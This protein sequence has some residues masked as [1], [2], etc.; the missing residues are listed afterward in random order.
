MPVSAP[1]TALQNLDPG[2]VAGQGG[3]RV[4]QPCGLL[5]AG[6]VRLDGQPR[7]ACLA[8]EPEHGADLR[9]Q[10]ARWCD[11]HVG[12]LAPAQ[13]SRLRPVDGIPF[14]GREPG[15]RGGH[16]ALLI[17]MRRY[18]YRSSPPAVMTVGFAGV[19]MAIRATSAPTAVSPS[20]R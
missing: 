6:Q 15:R 13:H 19:V 5:I 9:D 11:S 7:R 3:D 8:G 2:P 17:G 18:R 14:A 20:A 16:P 1:G 4:A 12:E 10:A